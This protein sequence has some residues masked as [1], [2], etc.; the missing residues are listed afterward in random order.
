M[1][2][3]LV[4]DLFFLHVGGND[5]GVGDFLNVSEILRQ[6]N[7]LRLRQVVV[8]EPPNSDRNGG[9]EKK[10]LPLVGHELHD[11]T[12]LLGETHVQH[13]VRFVEHEDF[14]GIQS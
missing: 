14:H 7:P 8:D 13:L 6:E 2:D 5:I 1:L 9:R 12:H 4:K 11:L 3:Q 10:G